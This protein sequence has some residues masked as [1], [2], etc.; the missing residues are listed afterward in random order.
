M[1]SVAARVLEKKIEKSC[2][3][4]ERPRPAKFGRLVRSVAQRVLNIET[5]CVDVLH[6]PQ[7]RGAFAAAIYAFQRE[8]ALSAQV[9]FNNGGDAR[10]TGRFDAGAARAAPAAAAQH[11]KQRRNRKKG[12]RDVDVKNGGRAER[13]Q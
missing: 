10:E 2:G 12:F 5:R 1:Y 6:R 11:D 4:P 7:A 9:E 3:A 8:H 13:P